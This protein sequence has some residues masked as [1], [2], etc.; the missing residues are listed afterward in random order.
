M[1]L[2]EQVSDGVAIV[3]AHGRIDSVTARDLNEKLITL[4]DSGTARIVLDLKNIVYVSSAGFRVL[5]V[6]DRA[7]QRKNGRLAL[8][9]I[10][11]DVMRLFEIG[12]FSDL[13]SI[14]PTRHEAVSGILE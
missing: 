7:S 8:C 3:E 11:G 13:F 1:Q 10:S 14:Y 4:I 12:A 2:I 5:V 6:A 9:E